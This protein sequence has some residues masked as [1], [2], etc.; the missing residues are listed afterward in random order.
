M[1]RGAVIPRTSETK[2]R[3]LPHK[4]VCCSLDFGVSSTDLGVVLR[5]HFLQLAQ[6]QAYTPGSGPNTSD[7]RASATDRERLMRSLR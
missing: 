5:S 3:R 2:L 6:L 4:M 7:S 1:G